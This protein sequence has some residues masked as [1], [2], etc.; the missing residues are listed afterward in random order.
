MRLRR[1]LPP[2]LRAL[3]VRPPPP[4]PDGGPPCNLMR[5]SSDSDAAVMRGSSGPPGAAKPA[6]ERGAPRIDPSI[7]N[8]RRGRQRASPIRQGRDEMEIT[9]GID[10]SKARLDVH[11]HPTGE[12]FALGNDEAGVEALCQRLGRLEGVLGIGLEASG[13][14]ERL[15]VAS[16]AEA[17]L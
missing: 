5:A 4:P 9:V 11:V 1:D 10:V 14:Y 7:P 6:R 16:L 17:G 3:C 8:S 2:L 13:R 12:S 15:A